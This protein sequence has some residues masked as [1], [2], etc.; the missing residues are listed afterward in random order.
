MLRIIVTT[1]Q[2]AEVNVNKHEGHLDKIKV[3][4]SHLSVII[5]DNHT[6]VA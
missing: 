1:K 2:I 6:I 3:F 4:L 5:V